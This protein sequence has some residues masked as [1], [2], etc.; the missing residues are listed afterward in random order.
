VK[1]EWIAAFAASEINNNRPRPPYSQTLLVNSISSRQGQLL[2]DSYKG[3]AR[4]ARE[5][6][7][8]PSSE[9][10]KIAASVSS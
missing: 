2:R 4:R 8:R 9:F 6:D 10:Q 7:T 5:T 1:T 3:R